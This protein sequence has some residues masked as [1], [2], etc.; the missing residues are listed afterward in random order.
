M[1]IKVIKKVFT[2]IGIF[3]ILFAGAIS[4]ICGKD[5][6]ALFAH[7][8]QLEVLYDF[9]IPEPYD[10]NIGDIGDGEDEKWY[11]LIHS[12]IGDGNIIYQRCYHLP[13]SNSQ[14]STIKYYVNESAK[15]NPSL[16]WGSCLP[17]GIVDCVKTSFINSMKKWNSIYL[18]K[19]NS[20]GLL[21]KRKLINVIEG[22]TDDFNLII[23]PKYVAFGD[24]ASAWATWDNQSSI[25]YLDTL[26]NI[27]H[28]HCDNWEIDFNLFY[29]NTSQ[30][31]YDY[32]ES[33]FVL[34][35]VGAHEL[36]HVLGL[37]DIDNCE[38][39]NSNSSY[40]HE[41]LLMGY[42]SGGVTTRQPDIT[43]KDLIGAAI[44]RGLHAADD[45]QWIYHSSG[46]GV[47]KLICSICNGVK[48]VSS[49]DDIDYVY[50]KDCGDEHDLEDGNMFAVARSEE[51]TSELQSR[52]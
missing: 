17:S 28:Y 40:H 4:T 26:N 51:H 49:L 1:E 38:T 45:H 9:C 32:N 29:H 8:A 11:E 46:H 23:Y 37:F 6:T 5:Y 35:Q 52:E 24:Y 30:P 7:D 19:Y 21:T 50:Y 33:N 27:D 18:Y 44:T 13:H 25:H 14:V 39:I 43:Y 3:T 42:S 36:G 2:T 47:Y 16:T 20:L 48:Y 15:D 22:S 12:W 10:N 34:Y 41:E 31:F